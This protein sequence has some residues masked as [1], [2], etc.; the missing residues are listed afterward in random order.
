MLH[1][2]KLTDGD[3]LATVKQRADMKVYPFH[4]AISALMFA[5]VVDFFPVICCARFSAI[6]GLPHGYAVVRIYLY[7]EGTAAQKL[8][9]SRMNDGPPLL[10]GMSNSNWAT[11]D[12]D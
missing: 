10:Y 1:T 5:I 7:L 11:Y 2:T 9:C 3:A 6:P 8:T 4:S 12:I